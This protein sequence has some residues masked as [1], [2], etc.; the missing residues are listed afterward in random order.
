MG[1][2]LAKFDARCACSF[3]VLLEP[4][5]KTG[6]RREGR[7]KSLGFK[8]LGFK[9]DLDDRKRSGMPREPAKI[10]VLLT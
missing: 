4:S 2:S 10:A 5:R 3:G 6:H 1:A 7:R 9:R 8:S